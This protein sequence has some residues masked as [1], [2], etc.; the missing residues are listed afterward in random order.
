MIDDADA[1]PEVGDFAID[2]HGR[3]DLT[4]VT[5]RIAFGLHDHPAGPVQ[6]VPFGLVVAVAVEYLDA[7]ILP[8]GDVDPALRVATQIVRNVEFTRSGSGL[9]PGFQRFAVRRIHVD[10]GIAVAIRNVDVSARRKRRVRTAMERLTA[11]VRRRLAGNADRQ[12]HLAAGRALA[13]AVVP[14]VGAVKRLV[15]AYVQAV[16]AVEY[17]FAP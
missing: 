12:Q 15:G 13:H 11:H 2:R 6:V 17:A 5:Q 4:D 10:S 1:R 14:V 9:S 3:A 7:M 8:V 16:G